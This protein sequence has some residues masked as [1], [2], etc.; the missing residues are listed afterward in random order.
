MFAAMPSLLD[1]Q[2]GLQAVHSYKRFPLPSLQGPAE[3]LAIT[4]A[5]FCTAATE[6]VQKYK[7]GCT[8]AKKSTVQSSMI[9][10]DTAVKWRDRQQ[11]SGWAWLEGY[12]SNATDEDSFFVALGRALPGNGSL[13]GSSVERNRK[14][15][16]KGRNFFGTKTSVKAFLAEMDALMQR[17]V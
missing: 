15:Y 2:R 12:D 8:T 3:H 1:M 9:L 11:R 13:S 7:P 16:A 4:N 5:A 14:L 6:L 10:R 17:F